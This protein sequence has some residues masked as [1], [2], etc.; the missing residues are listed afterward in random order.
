VVL[1]GND[2]VA[3]ED[4]RG[5]GKAIGVDFSG[6]THNRFEVYSGAGKD[7]RPGEGVGNEREGGTI[8][9]GSS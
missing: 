1:H 3:V 7:V 6:V 8:R 4:V 9:G 2:K 5:I